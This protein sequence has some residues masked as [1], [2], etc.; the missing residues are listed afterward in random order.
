MF[1]RKNHIEGEGGE[2]GEKRFH[3]PRGNLLLKNKFFPKKEKNLL[4][5][6]F[7]SN[8]PFWVPKKRVFKFLG[9]G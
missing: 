3:S 7:I 2:D 6:F 8:F 9:K 1:S 5:K 4:L